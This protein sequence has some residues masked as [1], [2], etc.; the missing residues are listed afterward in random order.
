MATRFVKNVSKRVTQTT[1][2]K[3]GTVSAGLGSAFMMSSMIAPSDASMQMYNVSD[4][5]KEAP[6][7]FLELDA[8][9]KFEDMDSQIKSVISDND[10]VEGVSLAASGS[11]HSHSQAVRAEGTVAFGKPKTQNDPTGMGG[12]FAAQVFTADGQAF[13]GTATGDTVQ[14][15]YVASMGMG[16]VSMVGNISASG[17]ED[18]I[19]G[20]LTVPITGP[21]V[22]DVRYQGA[23]QAKVITMSFSQAIA[24]NTTAGVS[25]THP[26]GQGVIY[27]GRLSYSTYGE[28]DAIGQDM[29]QI[30]SQR[31]KKSVTVLSGTTMGVASLG[32]YHKLDNG[33]ES[34]VEVEHALGQNMTNISAG[35]K[36]TND[37]GAAHVTASNQGQVTSSF[38]FALAPMPALAI[39]ACADFNYADMQPGFG[40]GLKY[41]VE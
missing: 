33:L 36:Y 37:F 40:L 13:M 15:R 12:T 4:A 35:V 18:M 11:Q 25:V 23:A 2:K 7:V 38:T 5:S 1:F 28:S 24:P 21:A 22:L 30:E 31:S 9:V 3:A 14:A 16:T 20:D 32:H 29:T 10:H 6:I 41:N 19:M 34:S 39:T 17:E 8:P 26:F 27:N